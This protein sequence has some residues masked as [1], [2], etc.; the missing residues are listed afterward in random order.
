M[1]CEGNALDKSRVC[2]LNLNTFR[3]RG[4]FTPTF[5]VNW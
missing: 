1:Q 2:A 3:T 4:L 5:M